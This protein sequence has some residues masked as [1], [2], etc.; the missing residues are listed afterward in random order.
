[1]TTVEGHLTAWARN[2]TPTQRR[3]GPTFDDLGG[4]PTVTA[5][6]PA[7]ANGPLLPFLIQALAHHLAADNTVDDV[8]PIRDA[9]LDAM[10]THDNHTAYA[11][12]TDALAAAP[13]LAAALGTPLTRTLVARLRAATDDEDDLSRALIGAEA[14]DCLVQLTLA[15]VITAAKVLGALDEATEDPAALAPELATRLPRL[16]GVLHAHHPDAGL[17]QALTRFLALDHTHLDAAF[18]LALDDLRTALETDD[19]TTMAEQLRRTRDHFAAITA[20]DPDRVDA[21]LY[22]A[23]L[24]AVL[25]LSAPDART[26]VPLAAAE[27]RTALHR[28]TSW[29]RGAATVTWAAGRTAGITAWAELV[30]IL[31]AAAPYLDAA[32]PW[33]AGGPAVLSPLLRA[34][35]AHHSVAVAVTTD[36]S[37]A[38]AARILVMPIVEDT[39]LRH[40][41]RS[42]ILL[43]AIDHDD[44]FRDDPAAYQLRAAI[45][46]AAATQPAAPDGVGERDQGKARRWHRVADV[47]GPEEFA[48]LADTISDR[49][50]DRLELELRTGEDVAASIRDPKYDRLM[51]RLLDD[52]GR[53]ADWLPGIA[54]EFNAL[55][56]VTVRF[57]YHCYDIGRKM[58]GSYTEFLRLRDKDGRKQKVDEALFHQYYREWISVTG[59]FRVVNCEVDDRAGGRADLVFSFGAVHFSVECKIEENDATETGL[60]TYVS[61]AT[62]YQN[63]SAAFAILLALDKTVG[64][65]GAV[66]IFDSIWIE[67]VQRPG[68][69]EPCRVVIVRVPGGREQPNRLRPGVRQP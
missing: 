10:K 14:A 53:S 60:R 41:H 12:A 17:D 26:R 5:A 13:T 38:A 39:F 56:D 59:L 37:P 22:R 29:R 3:S 63:T 32:D 18:E 8:A 19:Y 43:H 67:H 65:E 1:M 66:N 4:T 46:R 31:A 34:Y 9:V 2:A 69:S 45:E 28:Y 36:A 48:A 68:E 25:G 42:R 51:S 54:E 44:A 11:G 6:A 35:T 33:Y 40:E 21:H 61:Q 30:A 27:L 55:L 24:D 57:A 49:S 20:T 16:L 7:L 64:A 23:A 52:L 47:F 62:E 50:L 15:D 58:G